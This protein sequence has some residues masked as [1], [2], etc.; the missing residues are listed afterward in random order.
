MK[1]YKVSEIAIVATPSPPAPGYLKFYPK[2][3]GFYMLNS[4]GVETKLGGV[5]V[6][7]HNIQDSENTNLPKQAILKFGSGFSVANESG[8]TVVTLAT[9]EG[10]WP[11]HDNALHTEDYATNAAFQAHLGADNPHSITKTTVGLGAVP[12]L[13]TTEAVNKAHDQN[14]D[15]K[16]AEG[17]ADEIT[18]A[19]LR[20]MA[21][22]FDENGLLKPDSIPYQ[23]QTRRIGVF[24]DSENQVESS[25]EDYLA[26]CTGN[27][28]KFVLPLASQ[29]K[30]ISYRFRHIGGTYAMNVERTGDDKVY[31]NLSEWLGV[32][33]DTP[34][35][36]FVLKSDGHD[37][38]I[39]TDSGLDSANEI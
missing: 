3:D 20:L 2:T 39:V 25:F 18:A 27:H 28:V 19:F 6:E 34:G 38:I 24:D 7:G 32:T 5:T 14:K 36:W 33:T 17:T 15:T 12:N 16:L 4:A 13:N 29:S 31:H 21:D 10:G 11:E 30:H 35:T 8:K 22:A 26:D 37:W 1:E 9:G 23:S